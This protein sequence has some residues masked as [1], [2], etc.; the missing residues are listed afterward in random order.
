MV[1]KMQG[2]DFEQVNKIFKEVHQFHCKNT[3]FF[4]NIDP[5]EKEFFIEMLKEKN[6][7]KLVEVKN[8]IVRGFL[9]GQLLQKEGRLSKSRKILF[10]DNLGVE[11]R[12]QKKGVGECL[13]GFAKS[14]AKENDCTEIE[15]NVWTFNSNAIKFYNHIGFQEI[16]KT[17]QLQIK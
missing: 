13:I 7:V 5:C 2:K 14:I 8:D 9:I 4:K 12:F 3:P 6:I 15:L 17:M 10:I 11:T 16:R 1:R